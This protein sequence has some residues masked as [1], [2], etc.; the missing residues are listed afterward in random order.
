M[1]SHPLKFEIWKARLREDCERNDKLIAFS[2]LGED[3][4]KVLYNCGTEP[5]LKGILDGGTGDV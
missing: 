2:N 4:L 5:S 3:T 1:A